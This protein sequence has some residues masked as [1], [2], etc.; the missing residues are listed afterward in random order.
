M[1]RVALAVGCLGFVGSAGC[2]EPRERADAGPCPATPCSIAAPERLEFSGPAFGQACFGDEDV[3]VTAIGGV[4]S[5]EVRDHAS[6]RAL[7]AGYQAGTDGAA[8]AVARTQ[9][10]VVM[11]TG[12]AA[13][14]ALLRIDDRDGLIDQVEVHAA[15][16]ARVHLEPDPQLAYRSDRARPW[17]VWT[18]AD[19]ALLIGLHA[20]DG[21]P[22]VDEAMAVRST[23]GAPF[24]TLAWDV[25][26][27]TVGPA[28]LALTVAAGDLAEPREF[29]VAATTTL[30]AVRGRRVN[31]APVAAG[32]AD[33]VCFEA[34]AG[35]AD[36]VFAPWTF[37]VSA[38]ATLVRFFPRNC[39]YVVAGSPGRIEVRGE[40]PGGM[41]VTVPVE[42]LAPAGQR[43]QPGSDPAEAGPSLGERA[44]G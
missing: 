18:G 42:V 19:A 11:L 3:K 20:A 9:G 25:R 13:G 23:D 37:T 5:V 39:V 26:R 4:Q 30:D 1:L 43:Q 12:R 27:Q 44:G 2:V 7:T 40:V 15:A 29:T 31:D 35:A 16:L 41:H 10:H 38:G 17:Q 21:R 8:V 32:N 28:G 22:L 6:G 14:T 36:V 24:T 34:S 33:L